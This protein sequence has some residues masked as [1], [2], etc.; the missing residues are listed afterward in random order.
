M[1]TP[2]VAKEKAAPKLRTPDNFS[3]ED[4]QNL[5]SVLNALL[6]DVTTVRLKASLPLA[7]DCFVWS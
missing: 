3:S 7:T 5:S 2:S 6:A 1:S 4:V